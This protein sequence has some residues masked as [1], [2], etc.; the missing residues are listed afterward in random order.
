M[1]IVVV[2]ASVAGVSAC[3]ALRQAGYEE[4]VVLLDGEAAAP[5]DRPPLSKEIL[6]GRMGREDIL[7]RLPEEKP[8]DF[9]PG[10][11]AQELDLGRKLITTDGGGAIAFDGLILATGSSARSLPGLSTKQGVSR[12]RTLEEA[13][14]IRSQLESASEVVVVGAGFIGLEVAS[15]AASLGCR[16]TVVEAA[17]APMMR[18]LPSRVGELFVALHH[19]HGVDVRCD[20]HLTEVIEDHGRAVGIRLGDGSTLSADHIV[21]G[22]GATPNTDWLCGSGVTVTDG[23]VCDPLLS[24]ADCVYA[25]GD[26]ARWPHPIYGSIRVEHWTTAAQHGRIAANNLLAELEGNAAARTVATDIPYFW[27]DQHGMKLQLAGWATGADAFHTTVTDNRRFAI[28]FEREGRLAAALTG[29]W[30]RLLGRL[31]QAIAAEVPIEEALE[32]LPASRVPPDVP[33]AEA[34]LV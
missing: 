27:S 15:S 12:L 21:L 13:M 9:R 34:L 28:L 29:S 22:L 31:R 25:C 10:T 1:R 11:L 5:Y 20:A 18:V 4:E 17:P 16:V 24:A 3:Q 32:T 30:P 26:V 8:V 19:Q 6:T 23:V 33:I 14:Q 7:L 2:G